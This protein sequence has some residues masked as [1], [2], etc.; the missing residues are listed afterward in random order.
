MQDAAGAAGQRP[1]QPGAAK[2]Q[3]RAAT[4]WPRC[5]PRTH[6]AA[7]GARGGRAPRA[8]VRQPAQVGLAGPARLRAVPRRELPA[9][10]PGVQAQP[11]SLRCAQGCFWVP[12]L[13]PKHAMPGTPPAT[14]HGEPLRCTLVLGNP[15][16]SHLRHTCAP[17]GST[18]AVAGAARAPAPGARRRRAPRPAAAAAAAGAAAARTRGRRRRA[19][20]GARR[21]GAAAGAWRTGGPPG[22]SSGTAPARRTAPARAQPPRHECSLLAIGWQ[23]CAGERGGLSSPMQAVHLTREPEEALHGAATSGVSSALQHAE[24]WRRLCHRPAPRA[25]AAGAGRSH[26]GA[27]AS[28]A[29]RPRACPR[30]TRCQNRGARAPPRSRARR[31]RR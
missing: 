25:S 12:S 15:Y 27:Q 1:A 8:A 9:A 23:R 29:L 14:L 30:A 26:A 4:R 17:I 16:P 19:R 20:R 5:G 3:A 21:S 2:A 18:G 13:A 6:P 31:P 22:W 11:E 10:A 7:I 24:R 28:S